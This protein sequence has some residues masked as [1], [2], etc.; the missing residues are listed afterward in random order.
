MDI[1]LL[2]KPLLHV[3]GHD[4]SLL[5][6]IAFPQRDLHIRSG[7]LKVESVAGKDRDGR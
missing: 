1:S 6:L 2:Q 7:V 5:G 3:L 4:V